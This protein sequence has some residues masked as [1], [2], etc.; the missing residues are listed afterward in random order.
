MDAEALAAAQSQL[1]QLIPLFE[2]T[3]QYLKMVDTADKSPR[4]GASAGGGS[5]DDELRAQL[6]EAEQDIR[7]MT[8]TMQ[9]LEGRRIAS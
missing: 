5:D 9:Q 1:M 3:K 6:E 7:L 2:E 8:A 4:V